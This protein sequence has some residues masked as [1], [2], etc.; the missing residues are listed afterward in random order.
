MVDTLLF[1][2]GN[3]LVHFDFGPARARLAEASSVAGDPLE[4]IAG[5]KDRLEI[6]DIDGP[7]FV[8][9][10]I[11][12]LGY[13][14]GPDAFRRT[15]EDIFSPNQ[16]MWEAVARAR[17]RYRLVLMSNTSEIHKE[18]LFRDF[19]IFE[20]FDGGVF[21]YASHRMKPDP[22]AYRIAVE[23][24][25]LRPAETLYVDDGAGN[26]EAGRRQ[27]FVSVLYDPQQHDRFLAEVRAL[28]VDL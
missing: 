12:K 19:A 15:W 10:A 26:V 20:S 27:G 4:T 7:T 28:G 9:A 16:P 2:I 3:V 8:D 13:H 11:E 6:G 25:G 22:E 17:E 14:G 1:D 5:L 24:L 23:E 18:S 21:S